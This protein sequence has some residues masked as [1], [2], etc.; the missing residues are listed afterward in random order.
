MWYGYVNV[1]TY[2][3]LMNNFDYYTNPDILS[4]I[5][6]HMRHIKNADDREDCRQEIF[7][8][9]YDFMP[10]DTDDAIRLVDKIA[11][12]FRRSYIDPHKGEYEVKEYDRISL[13][14]GNYQR[15]SHIGSAD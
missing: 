7:A 10:L 5:N 13:G 14:D 9:L 6:T 3:M 8:N 12:R 15:K 11:M 4:A 2:G 1:R